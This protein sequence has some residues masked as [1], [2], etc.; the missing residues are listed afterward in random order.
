MKRVV[1]GGQVL[2]DLL[3]QARAVPLEEVFQF[4]RVF[5]RH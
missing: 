5:I 2:L 3:A 1:D 4:D